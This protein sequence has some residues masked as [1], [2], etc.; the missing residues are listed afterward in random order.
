M[1]FTRPQIFF[2]LIFTDALKSQK[3]ILL[4]FSPDLLFYFSHLIFL[5]DSTIDWSSERA[6]SREKKIAQRSSLAHTHIEKWKSFSFSS[7]DR[8]PKELTFFS[9]KYTRKYECT[10]VKN[11]VK[12]GRKKKSAK[13]FIFNFFFSLKKYKTNRECDK[14]LIVKFY[15]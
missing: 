13:S 14:K 12:W 10:Y 11:S 4:T 8:P 1:F 7:R 15:F 9:C 3:K 5:R 2:F 6:R